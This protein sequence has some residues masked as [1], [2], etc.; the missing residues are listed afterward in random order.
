MT[1]PVLMSKRMTNK[2]AIPGGDSMEARGISIAE[3]F[4]GVSRGML[5]NGH[6]WTRHLKR[7]SENCGLSGWQVS[8]EGRGRREIGHKMRRP[9]AAGP[10]T[11]LRRH[12]VG[13]KPL[14]G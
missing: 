11:V 3:G 9:P 5:S 14:Q 12:V 13:A 8:L 6:L 1:D 4:L 7:E 2:A 10:A